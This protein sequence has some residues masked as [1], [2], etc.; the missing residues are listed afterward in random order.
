MKQPALRFVLTGAASST[1]DEFSLWISVGEYSKLTE[2]RGANYL[3]GPGGS[4]REGASFVLRFIAKPRSPAVYS[5]RRANPAVIC[6]LPY[7]KKRR[8]VLLRCARA[9]VLLLVLL[10]M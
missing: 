3:A 10:L 6:N 2:M 8:G 9:R 5:M 1:V 4:G 7:K